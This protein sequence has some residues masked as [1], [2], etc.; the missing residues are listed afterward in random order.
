VSTTRVTRHIRAPRS[1]VYAALLDPK[2][3]QQW[4]VPDEMTSDVHS[5]DAREGGTFR[6]SL[7]YD[8]P[9]AAGK[10][11][12]QTDTF[13]GRFVKLVRDTEVV[14]A[15]QFE[16]DDPSMAGEMTITYSLV[17]ADGGT[18]LV[19]VHENIPPGVA[20]ADNELGFRMSLDKLAKLL[21]T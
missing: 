4:M 17:D 21:A 5:F 2:A 10:T 19:A 7:T 9:T 8:E 1:R 3:V 20:P 16:S 14:Q 12:S 11:T 13:H 15:V 18:D 6:I